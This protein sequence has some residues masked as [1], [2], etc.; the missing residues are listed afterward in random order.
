[1][2]RA[3]NPALLKEGVDVAAMPEGMRQELA[4]HELDLQIRLW[5]CTYVW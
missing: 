5:R 1:M 4:R 3:D 2:L